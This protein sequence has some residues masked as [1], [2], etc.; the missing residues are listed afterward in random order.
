[1]EIEIQNLILKL[2]IQNSILKHYKKLES[3]TVQQALKEN[4]T[5]SKSQKLSLYLNENSF[6]QK[7]KTDID[8]KNSITSIKFEKYLQETY[9]F[10]LDDNNLKFNLNT[11]NIMLKTSP[12]INLAN[13][14]T[15]VTE[16]LILYPISYKE[17]ASETFETSRLYLEFSKILLIF[18]KYNK[19][20]SIK[21]TQIALVDYWECFKKDYAQIKEDWELIAG[22]V[23]NGR[24][25]EVSDGETLYL[26]I[27]TNDLPNSKFLESK[28]LSVPELS[29]KEMYFCFKKN[30]INKIYDI[31]RIKQ[32]NKYYYP[33]YFSKTSSK[34]FK[35]LILDSFKPYIGNTTQEICNSLNLPSNQ[36]NPN[37]Y[38]LIID[39]ILGI[40]NF[41]ETY[42]E[43]DASGIELRTIL[44]EPDKKIKESIPLCSFNY[45]DITAEEWDN[46]K[47]Y[48]QITSPYLFIIFNHNNPSLPYKLSKVIFWNVPSRDFNIIREV[49]IDTKKKIINKQYNRFIESNSC[50]KIHISQMNKNNNYKTMIASRKE[51]VNNKYFCFNNKYIQHEILDKHFFDSTTILA[52]SASIS[53]NKNSSKQIDKSFSLKDSTT[54]K[55]NKVK[56]RTS[57]TNG[58]T[59]EKKK[60]C[61]KIFNNTQSELKITYPEIY[62]NQIIYINTKIIESQKS[63]NISMSNNTKPKPFS[64]AIEFMGPAFLKNYYQVLLSSIDVDKAGNY[65]DKYTTILQNKTLL[66]FNYTSEIVGNFSVIKAN[67]PKVLTNETKNTLKGTGLKEQKLLEKSSYNS[68][69]D[70]YSN[71][72]IVTPE[73]KYSDREKVQQKKQEYTKTTK[74]L[75]DYANVNLN[76]GVS[77][78]ETDNLANK[79]NAFNLKR[80]S[81]ILQY[82]YGEQ[83]ILDN[84]KYIDS[85]KIEQDDIVFNTTHLPYSICSFLNSKLITKVSE[86]LKLSQ[87][88]F[89]GLNN[90]SPTNKRQILH[91]LRKVTK[92][93]TVNEKSLESTIFDLI[94]KK[95]FISRQDLLDSEDVK[96][97]SINLVPI[98]L[99]YMEKNK[100]IVL[101]NE[102]YFLYRISFKDYI[103]SLKNEIN[104]S[105]MLKLIKNEPKQN[106]NS[107]FNVTLNEIKNIECEVLNNRPLLIEDYFT[108]IFEKYQWNLKS[109]DL[110]FMIDDNFS[111]YYLNKVYHNG[112]CKIT[113]IQED[114]SI[115]SW[116]KKNIENYLEDNYLALNGKYY[117]KNSL[118]QLNSLIKN[119]ASEETS[120]DT[121][122]NIYKSRLTHNLF[123]NSNKLFSIMEIREI[124]LNSE[125]IIMGKD[126]VFRYYD[127]SKYNLLN[128]LAEIDFNNYCD[129]EISTNLIFRDYPRTMK[130]F[131]I[132]NHY[133]L[134][135]ILWNLI[136]ED[137][138]DIKFIDSPNLII[139]N[140]SRENQVLKLLKENSPIN[141]ISLAIKYEKIYGVPCCT[142]LKN[143]FGPISKYL[144]NSKYQ[145]S[146][147]DLPDDEEFIYL[148]N[149]LNYEIYDLMTVKKIY[150]DKFGKKNLKKLDDKFIEK[151]NFNITGNIILSK[152]YDNLKSYISMLFLKNECID[153][154][155]DELKVLQNNSTCIKYIKKA[156]MSFEIIEF[157]KYKYRKISYFYSFNISK[158][159]F[160]DFA[161]KCISESKGDYFTIYSL[162]KNG[163]K[164]NLLEIGF[165]TYLYESL[166]KSNDKLKFIYTKNGYLFKATNQSISKANLVV[167]IIRKE[168][169]RTIDDIMYDFES[170]YK[171][172]IDEMDLKQIAAQRG[173]YYNEI[174]DTIYINHYELLKEIE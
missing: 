95:K 92:Y 35:S 80:N 128:L 114:N 14:S 73:N 28:S 125:N 171:L 21:D 90:L 160:V 71:S 154:T 13:I 93:S 161:E 142:V 44:I 174:M 126:D 12:I 41:Q 56:Q 58:K 66:N 77:S 165:D 136:D 68:N 133:E 81:S 162:K 103:L 6:L 82:I 43:F 85:N 153:L 46:S 7:E 18:Y 31:L 147:S 130:K 127:E 97:F 109:F 119:F 29:S 91:F 170:K 140:N 20:V 138:S 89:W 45:Y 70:N 169:K 94:K 135:Y 155:S 72:T 172:S 39:K 98:I 122:Y 104:K 116:L 105:I 55:V 62:N 37:M 50:L 102:Y 24:V 164:N 19:N 83:A 96:N 53:P 166:L 74:T 9:Y 152:R 129:M 131:D 134:Y 40:K 49:W 60:I 61:F 47:L 52:S 38:Q 69:I 8:I 144:V 148:K 26:G 99:K 111:Y 42:Y 163:M 110:I 2:N 151:L 63:L 124:V 118:S 76:N 150:I 4:N 113:S 57:L 146:D 78:I 64:I 106:I 143:Y 101:L 120:I 137:E 67:A 54:T 1:M 75:F 48:N 79:Q 112:K 108:S 100:R 34:S 27:C 107:T 117:L 16:N 121:F 65:Y 158:K 25:N 86:I 59:N 15:K 3:K 30:Y 115:P 32:L 157:S 139:G 36:L 168:G 17:I 22:K 123:K 159:D 156:K 145:L 132:R 10:K 173:L 33:R 84:I 149:N 88:E 11:A 167:S 51:I 5:I 87:D 23:K 141:K